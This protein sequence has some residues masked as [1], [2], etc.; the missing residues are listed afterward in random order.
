MH[1]P[2]SITLRVP[3]PAPSQRFDIWLANQLSTRLSRSRI[4]QLI[5]QGA[6]TINGVHALSRKSAPA[7]AK[8][9]VRIPAPT[10]AEPVPQDIPLDVVFEDADLLVLN[11]PPNC[12]VHPAPGH[13]DGTLVNALLFHCRD[14][15]GVGGVTRPG[16]VHRL[17][18]DTSGL[19]V[20]AKH[21]PSLAALARA[22][23]D[24]NVE[25]TYLA[26]VHGVPGPPAGRIETDIG[27]HPVDRKKMSVCP[28]RGRPAISRYRCRDVIGIVTEVQVGIETGRTHQ[29]R[30]HL[31]HIGCPI[32]GDPVYGSRSRDQQLKR[33]VPRTMLHAW[34]LRFPH[35]RNGRP[36][37]FD[38]PPP[39]DYTRL[40]SALRSDQ[41]L[42]LR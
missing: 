4:Q 38:I 28:P 18:R 27:R 13:A 3:D 40:R 37:S 34:K 17:D 8:V 10:P 14:L 15:K 2:E 33:P 32:L 7:G 6:V 5:R 30:V 42:K 21:G 23:K 20:V 39:V 36:V 24:R 12:V 31:A 26:I 9:T 11:K 35:P 19:M 1:D 41:C 22:F 16:I 29:I 25:K